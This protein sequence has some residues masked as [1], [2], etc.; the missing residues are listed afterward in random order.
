MIAAYA[1][2][3]DAAADPGTTS[4]AAVC[5]CYSPGALSWLGNPTLAMLAAAAGAGIVVVLF[6][7]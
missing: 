1:R 4:V 5:V 2:E 3:S 7:G 6:P